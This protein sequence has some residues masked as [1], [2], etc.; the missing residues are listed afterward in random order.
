M[1]IL[2]NDFFSLFICTGWPVS[3]TLRERSWSDQQ[4]EPVRSLNGFQHKKNKLKRD[5]FVSPNWGLE[6]PSRH[7]KSLR[8]SGLVLLWILRLFSGQSSQQR[9]RRKTAHQTTLATWLKQP[10]SN[11]KGCFSKYYICPL[12]SIS[13]WKN[14]YNLNLPG[15]VLNCDKSISCD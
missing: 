7:W 15:T 3:G 6:S 8:D 11:E 9:Q 10:L 4:D 2:E 13:H 1:I 12:Q 14:R 5:F